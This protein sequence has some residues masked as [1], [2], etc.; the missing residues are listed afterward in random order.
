MSNLFFV[1]I[2]IGGTNVD[3]LMADAAGN[4]IGF[5]T[6][7]IRHTTKRPIEIVMTTVEQLMTQSGVSPAAIGVGVPGLVDPKTG[8]VELA[9]NLSEPSIQLGTV[10]QRHFGVPV[11]V[12]NDANAYAMA[13]A[14]YLVDES[15]KNLAFITLGTGVG[16]GLILDGKIY[17]GS[18]NMAGE[19]GHTY[20]GPSTVPCQ[21]GLLGCLETFVAGP[22]L[23][24]QAK[25]AVLANKLTSLSTESVLDAAAVFKHAETGDAVS[26]EIVN[27]MC[28][29]LARATHTLMMSFDLQKI[30]IGGGLSRAGNALLLPILEKWAHMSSRSP[31]AAEMLQPSVLEIC[32]KEFKAGAWG[33]VAIGINGMVENDFAQPVELVKNRSDISQEIR[34][35]I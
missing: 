23:A 14:K 29:Y 13:A 1:G 10:L 28:S 35:V 3:A 24:R 18:K 19:I 31:M 33:A 27:E 22:A 26:Q 5:V 20:A 4:E 2:D 11:F 12:E 34:P 16:G 30:M 7:P 8:Q 21:C 6:N 25:E 15:V 17:H 9:V 32:P